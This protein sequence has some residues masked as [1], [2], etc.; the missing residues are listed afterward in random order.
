MRFITGVPF[1]IRVIGGVVGVVVVLGIMY[2]FW[3][4]TTQ[5]APAQ[6]MPF[7]HQRMV[8]A[9]V[10]CVFCHTTVQKGPAASIPSVEKCVG[11]HRVIATDR[12][13]IQQLMTYWQNQQPI[14]WARVNQLPRF[15]KFSHQPHVTVGAVNCEECHGDVGHMNEAQPVVR[16]DMGWCLN[17][18][19]KQPN[20][21]QLSD[22]AICHY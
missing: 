21:Q 20:G 2:Y 5:A 17:C 3:G 10:Q 8:Q 9:G 4:A 19:Q 7:P 18:H 11:C 15:V 12:P 22:C 13:A 6:P 14:P 16:M 1:A